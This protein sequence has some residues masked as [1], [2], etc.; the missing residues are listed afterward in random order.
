MMGKVVFIN[1][2][3]FLR[4]VHDDTDRDAPASGTLP[5]L[6]SFALSCLLTRR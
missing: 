6:L 5:F 4:V 2:A 3:G 1:A